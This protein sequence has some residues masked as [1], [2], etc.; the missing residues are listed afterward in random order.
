MRRQSAQNGRTAPLELQQRDRRCMFT[1]RRTC[2]VFQGNSRSL[3][4]SLSQ[5]LSN[6]RSTRQKTEFTEIGAISNKCRRREMKTIGRISLMLG[7]VTVSMWSASSAQGQTISFGAAPA[8]P[9]GVSPTSVATGSLTSSG[10]HDLAVTNQHGVLIL[11][12]D[13]S[14]G[15][16][17]GN[18][19]VAG[20]NPQS[21]V[22]DDFDGNG[23]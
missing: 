16:V 2:V 23:K 9:A 19:Y 8:F 10:R 7:M 11:L 12:N 18:G 6:S 4:L 17:A 13:G 3:S 22:I 5:F 1:S 14:G 15:M 20:T 21:V